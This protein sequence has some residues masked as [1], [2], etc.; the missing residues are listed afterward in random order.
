M[1]LL[2]STLLFYHHINFWLAEK[3]NKTKENEQ[4]KKSFKDQ[5]SKQKKTV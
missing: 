3:L 1:L 2:F 5:T 4:Q